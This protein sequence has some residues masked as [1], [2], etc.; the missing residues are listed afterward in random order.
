MIVCENGKKAKL[1]NE[2]LMEILQLSY[3]EEKFNDVQVSLEE[4]D[5]DVWLS[6]FTLEVSAAGASSKRK[7]VSPSWSPALSN[8]SDLHLAQFV[9]RLDYQRALKG[10]N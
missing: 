9:I 7:F 6:Y 5:E 10:A 3:Y 1:I 8:L 2:E 4:D